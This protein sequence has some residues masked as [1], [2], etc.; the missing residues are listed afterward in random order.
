MKKKADW[1]SKHFEFL[2]KHKDDKFVWGKWDCI[3]FVN[4]YLKAITGNDILKKTKG[5]ENWKDE[6]QAKKSIK[7]YGKTLSK[8]IGKAVEEQG[9]TEIPKSRFNFLQRG[10]LVCFKEE[11]ELAG[12]CD[13][14][15]ILGPGDN[16]IS[17][18]TS[19]NIVKAWRVD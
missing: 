6:I 17:L 7:D 14:Y 15:N 9:I 3:R 4:A 13:G 12:I 19:C 18:K 11:T 1:E 2:L 8:A 5:L 16:G 10:D